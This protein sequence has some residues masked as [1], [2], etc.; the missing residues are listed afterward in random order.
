M[1][2]AKITYHNLDDAVPSTTF[3]GQSFTHMKPVEVDIDDARNDGLIDAA[4]VNRSFSVEGVPAHDELMKLRE[5]R[6]ERPKKTEI[7]AMKPVFAA[8]EERDKKVEEAEK[9]RAKAEQEANDAVKK[10]NRGAAG[11]PPQPGASQPGSP[12]IPAA[13]PQPRPEQQPRPTPANLP[14]QPEPA[15]PAS[16]PASNNS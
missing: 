16:S 3:Y 11:V 2:K 7:E 14:S 6:G 8:R 1:A 9:V 12:V 10:A 15:H 5:K 13:S 4:L